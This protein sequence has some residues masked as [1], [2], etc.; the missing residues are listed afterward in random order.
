MRTMT[1]GNL[2]WSHS[3][4]LGSEFSLDAS[5]AAGMASPDDPRPLGHSWRIGKDRVIIH[6]HKPNHI[7]LWLGH[8]RPQVAFLSSSIVL[9]WSTF[10]CPVCFRTMSL[11][12]LSW[13]TCC[14][15][16]LFL[17]FALK[18][19][20]VVSSQCAPQWWAC[21]RNRKRNRG[22]HSLFWP[23]SIPTAHLT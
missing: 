8:S 14:I 21:N 13:A 9:F 22:T 7:E 18:W 3:P 23:T 12:M 2:K 20:Y 6:A 19:Q 5:L 16:G 10:H 11:A 15:F 4:V 17:H 1:L